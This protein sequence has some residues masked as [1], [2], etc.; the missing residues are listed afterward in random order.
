MAKKYFTPEQ[1]N[2]IIDCYENKNYSIKNI[3]VEYRCDPGTITRVLNENDVK[4]KDYR[5]PFTPEQEEYIKIQYNNGKSTVKLG[6]EFG[7]SAKAIGS[8][9]K[10]NEIV[11]T[12]STLLCDEDISNI[13]LDYIENSLTLEVISAKYNIAKRRL[14]DILQEKGIETKNKL[15]K[16]FSEEDVKEIIKMYTIGF[17]SLKKIGEKYNCD[18]SVI[19]NLLKKN[20]IEIYDR[21]LKHH[22]IDDETVC[23]E[24]INGLSINDLSK[25][26]GCSDTVITR[27][28]QKNNI[29]T[30]N[31]R[32]YNFSKEQVDELIRL[33]TTELKPTSELSVLFDCTVDRVNKILHDNNV[34]LIKQAANKITFSTEDI[35][36]IKSLHKTMSNKEIGSLFNCSPD[37]IRRLLNKEGV[38]T[39]KNYQTEQSVIDNIVIDYSIN[40]LSTRTL[41]EKYNFS[42]TYISKV[43]KENNVEANLRYII[44]VSSDEEKEIIRKHVE[45]RKTLTEI[46]NEYGINIK[47]LSENIFKKN[48]INIQLK[49]P[50]Q[51]KLNIEQILTELKTGKGISTIA[52]ENN[53]SFGTINSIAISNGIKTT[54]E[55][56]DVFTN[57]LI[58]KKE[59]RRFVFDNYQTKFVIEK[60]TNGATIKQISN[61]LKVDYTTI[62]R[63]LVNNNIKVQHKLLK[64]FT[65]QVEE[66]IC[67]EYVDNNKTMLE[68]GKLYNVSQSVIRKVLIKHNVEITNNYYSSVNENKIRYIL[69]Y[70][71]PTIHKKSDCDNILQAKEIDIIDYTKKIGIEYNGTYFHRSENKSET[72]HIDKTKEASSAGYKLYHVFDD[73]YVHDSVKIINRLLKLFK[74]GLYITE[75]TYDELEECFFSNTSYDEIYIEGLVKTKL[76][77]SECT[78]TKVEPTKQYY[79]FY[80][81]FGLLKSYDETINNV[82]Y[83]I[84]HKE[85]GLIG[86]ISINKTTNTVENLFIEDDYVITGLNKRIFDLY[87]NEFKPTELFIEIDRRY[88]SEPENLSGLSFEL[89]NETEPRIH[90]FKNYSRYIATNETNLELDSDVEWNIIHDCGTWKYKLIK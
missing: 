51:E 88:A 57:E 78:I 4:I 45:D 17:I 3:A 49:K 75:D 30:I 36:K 85:Y 63:V 62:H 15:Y 7:C 38:N 16:T 24:H 34:S 74:T 12:K 29:E 66:D 14:S 67:S 48:N 53:C 55:L 25:K 90:Y 9:L 69:G 65:E 50:A 81:A 84:E 26:Y 28:L 60:Y 43:L 31:H 41:S 64:T 58:L 8:F 80:T 72:Y 87:L 39:S 52:R 32:F 21:N 6:E 83:N 70:F 37:T 46:S 47:F 86:Y 44:S 1:V 59:N 27:I 5:I 19:S 54:N 71:I 79:Q 77:L 42:Q 40:K 61:F 89:I 18:K 11:V 23:N 13:I 2:H 20:K 33:Y 82:N 73:E 35:D 76:P 10:R 68:I 22:L 56:T